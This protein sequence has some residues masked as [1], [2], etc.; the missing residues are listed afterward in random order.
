MINFRLTALR[1]DIWLGEIGE[2]RLRD[3]STVFTQCFKF[4]I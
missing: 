3:I 1:L 2:H 4:R